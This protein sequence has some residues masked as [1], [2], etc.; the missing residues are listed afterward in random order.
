[1]KVSALL[2]VDLGTSSVKGVAFDLTGRALASR[3]IPCGYTIPATRV[4]RGRCARLVGRRTSDSARLDGRRVG[5]PGG[6]GR[7]DRP[8]ADIAAPRPKGGSASTARFSGSTSAARPR[9]C[10][11]RRE[12]ASRENAPAA[13]VSTPT[14]SAPS[15]PGCSGTRQSALRRLPPSSSR[16]A[17]RSCASP[18]PGPPTFPQH[19]S[20]APLYDARQRAWSGDVWRSSSIPTELPARDSA[21]RTTS[22][23]EVTAAAAR[24]TGL[25]QGTP[26]V[27]GG[28]DFAASALAAGVTEPGEAALML[29][30]A[31]NLILPFTARR[32]RHAADQQ[33][34]T[35]AAT[36]TWRWAR[37]CAARPGVVPRPRR[38]RGRATRCS[39]RGSGHG[40]RG[41]RRRA[42]P[43]HTCRASARRCGTR[44]RA[45]PSPGSPW[46]MGAG[47]CTARCWRAWRCRSAT[48]PR[49]R[50]SAA[51]APRGHRGERRRA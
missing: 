15:S 4:G 24:E 28:A 36:A 1:M 32:L 37:R 5:Q 13:T 40:A 48:A 45:A 39:T 43:A 41:R 17:T 14:I 25:R 26:V 20:V 2:G 12:W 16:T 8:G 19:R 9:S 7:R 44:A 10:R 18:G 42:T 31:G 27:V 3:E 35:W 49:S 38:A 34:T 29:G 33:R 50:A 30:T 21:Q 22:R 23:G 51:C 6:R 46:R 11:W 47:T